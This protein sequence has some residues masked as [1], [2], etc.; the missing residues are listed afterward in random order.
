M[1][2]LA[3][4]EW[5]I[6]T[7]EHPT[8]EAILS[9]PEEENKHLTALAFLTDCLHRLDDGADWPETAKFSVEERACAPP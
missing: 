6:D 2:P 4:V 8:F 5:H 9:P 1:N 7:A 3:T